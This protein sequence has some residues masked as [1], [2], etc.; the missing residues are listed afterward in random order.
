MLCQEQSKLCSAAAPARYFSTRFP[1]LMVDIYLTVIQGNAIV[2]CVLCS[3]PLQPPPRTSLPCLFLPRCAKERSAPL[4]F[5]SF[6]HS[7]GYPTGL[8][9]ATAGVPAAPVFWEGHQLRLSHPETASV[10]EHGA[11]FSDQSSLKSFGI[12]TYRFHVRNLF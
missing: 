6:A 5:Q 7:C 3:C 10:R 4:L 8:W 9:G 2:P 12:R 11:P 1:L